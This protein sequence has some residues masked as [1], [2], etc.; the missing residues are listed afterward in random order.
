MITR[1]HKRN[2]TENHDP[3]SVVS[4]AYNEP[5]GAIKTAEVGLRLKPFLVDA[6]TGEYTTDFSTIRRV[7]KGVS[8]AI[9]NTSTNALAITVTDL[10]G[11]A[12]LA[13]G[14]TNTEGDV[15]IPCTPQAW[16][17][18]A[19]FDKTLAIAESDDLLVF[20]VKDNTRVN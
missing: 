8:L 20:I 16:T 3:S 10:E 13:P 5:A 2:A 11:Q 17:H 12:A 14:A 7:G 9:F 15:G 19:T 18:I 4:I 1:K 6:E